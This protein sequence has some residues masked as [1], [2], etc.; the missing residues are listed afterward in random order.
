VD[1]RE[2]YGEQRLIL[3]GMVESRLLVVAH[4]SSPESA[5]HIRQ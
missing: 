5:D 3:V 1:D 2:D 4:T